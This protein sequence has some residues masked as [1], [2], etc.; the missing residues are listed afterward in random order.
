MFL[1]LDKMVR[2]YETALGLVS[3]ELN[4]SALGMP[5]GTKPLPDFVPD[6]LGIAIIDHTTR[7]RGVGR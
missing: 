4:M 5:K 6:N 7:M 2:N 1:G 3:D